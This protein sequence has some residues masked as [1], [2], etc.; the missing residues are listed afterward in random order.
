MNNPAPSKSI[1][2]GKLAAFKFERSRS[3]SS[4]E[5]WERFSST[6]TSRAA[7]AAAQPTGFAAI[8]EPTL[9]RSERGV[10]GRESD[11]LEGIEKTHDVVVAQDPGKGVH[12]YITWVGLRK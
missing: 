7:S 2:C 3:L 1:M 10:S 9:S 8:V 5:R 11:L 4:L 12:A 6:R